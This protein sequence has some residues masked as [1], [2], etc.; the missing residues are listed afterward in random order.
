VGFNA[1]F[2]FWRPT[3]QVA[4]AMPFSPGTAGA[5]FDVGV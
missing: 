2:L 3:W 5:K 4:S 1:G